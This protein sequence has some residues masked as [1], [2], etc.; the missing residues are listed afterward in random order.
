MMSARRT[1]STSISALAEVIGAD[2]V[3]V[4]AR[5]EH[6]PL[7]QGDLAGRRADDDVLLRGRLDGR[8]D[9]D[10]LGAAVFAHLA[11]ELVPAFGVAGIDLGPLDAADGGHRLEL[12]AGLFAGAEQAHGLRVGAG[13][14]F[15]G[16]S[17][18]GPRAQLAEVIGLDERDQF[19]GLDLRQPDVKLG[20]RAGRRVDFPTDKSQVLGGGAHHVQRDA[21]RPRR[22]AGR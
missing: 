6:P 7:E 18:R 10:D 15:G 17:A 19:A 14:V 11:G 22:F 12:R 8:M 13:H 9:G 2:D 1:V 20:L 3:E 21:G 4:R 5:L 16:N